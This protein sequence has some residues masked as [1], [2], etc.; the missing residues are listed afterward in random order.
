MGRVPKTNEALLKEFRRTFAFNLVKTIVLM[1]LLSGHI[2]GSEIH[3][4]AASGNLEKV[5]LPAQKRIPT[6]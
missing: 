2:F 1:V 5:R 3:D 6:A 4:L